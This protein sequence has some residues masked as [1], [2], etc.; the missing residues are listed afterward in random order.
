MVCLKGYKAAKQQYTIV[1]IEVKLKMKMFSRYNELIMKA[2]KFDLSLEENQECND[3]YNELQLGQ[4]DNLYS[5][6]QM[7]YGLNHK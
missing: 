1:P 6:M 5:L 7:K 4:G 2:L 3:L